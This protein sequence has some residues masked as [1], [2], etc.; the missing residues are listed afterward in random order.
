MVQ[1]ATTLLQA[2]LSDRPV[3]LLFVGSGRLGNQLRDAAVAS[4]LTPKEERT[5]PAG[6][7][8]LMPDASF[9][10]FLN[11]SEIAAAYVA[12]D[13]LVLPQRHRRTVGTGRQRSH[14]RCGLPAIV[15]DQCGCAE[16]LPAAEWTN[17]LVFRCGDVDD[18]AP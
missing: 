17:A 16:D 5:P 1:A 12:A 11:Q 18:L 3:H 8:D 14:G 15:S 4:I 9:A 13:A 2:S 10:G 6:R 7:S